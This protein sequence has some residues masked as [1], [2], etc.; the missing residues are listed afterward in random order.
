MFCLA[1]VLAGGAA[2]GARA[3]T[4]ISSITDPRLLGST[5]IDFESVPI[6]SYS[7]LVVSTVT[8]GPS[9]TVDTSYSNTYN[10]PGRSI[11]NNAGAVQNL[12]I[13]F[14]APVSAFGFNF[15]ASDVAWTL[16]AFSST[17]VLLASAS[18]GPTFGSNA[19]EFYGLG[20]GSPLISHVTL[21]AAS[22][23]DFI[24][25]DN[26]RFVAIPEPSTVALLTL[27]GLALVVVAAMR[28]RRTA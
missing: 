28:H 13:D 27:G 16:S 19:G 21:T 17:N 1:A 22:S 23:G 10:N 3:Q 2:T 7:P 5:L 24:F 15:G 9:V 11:N 25:I 14:S 20:V 18:I 4:L 12:T 26:F 8:F 6:N